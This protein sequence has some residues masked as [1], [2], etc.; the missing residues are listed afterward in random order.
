MTDATDALPADGE[1][2]A[3]HAAGDQSELVGAWLETLRALTDRAAH[4]VRGALNGVSLNLEVVRARTDK[5]VTDRLA[6]APFAGAAAEQ[7]AVVTARVEALLALTRAARAPIEVRAIATQVVTLLAPAMRSD[8]GSLELLPDDGDAS[9]VTTAEP[10]AVR[11]AVGAVLLAAGRPRAAL[12]C[13]IVVRDAIILQVE[14]V[15]DS[16]GVAADI[17]RAAADAGIG[18]EHHQD[19]FLVAFPAQAGRASGHGRP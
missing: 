6:V 5:G 7:L 2:A 14:G 1:A 13:R 10:D 15:A 9:T 4:E 18:I 3:R 11:L 17:V 16:S 12:L 8:G 19:A